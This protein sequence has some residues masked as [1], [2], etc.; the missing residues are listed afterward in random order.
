M[1]KKDIPNLLSVIRILLVPV[2]VYMFMTGKHTGAVVVFILSGLTDV[3]DGYI[4]RKYNYISDLGKFLDPFADKLTQFSAFVCLYLT[5][6]VPLWMPVLYFIKELGTLIGALV[7]FRNKKKVVKS[8]IF[9]KLATFFVFAFVC[10]D[11]LFGKD[12]SKGVVTGLCIAICVYFVFAGIMYIVAE[13]N[14]KQPDENK[15]Q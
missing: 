14:S 15:A 2:F 7:V 9:G 11:I 12:L 3:L 1:K 10:V 5:Q 13:M 6:L 8:N 4:A